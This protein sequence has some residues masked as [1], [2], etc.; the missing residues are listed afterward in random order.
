MYETRDDDT[1][2]RD[3]AAALGYL[4]SIQSDVWRKARQGTVRYLTVAVPLLTARP[5][6]GKAAR[7]RTDRHQVVA[8]AAAPLKW[9][10]E[11]GRDLNLAGPGPSEVKVGYLTANAWGCTYTHTKIG[12]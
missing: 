3:T 12:L 11:R 4:I 1:T 9:R 2:R 6:T 7:C 5:G 10:G 8:V